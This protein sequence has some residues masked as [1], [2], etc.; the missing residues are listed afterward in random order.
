MNRCIKMLTTAV[1][2]VCQGGFPYC[3]NVKGVIARFCH[4]IF[5][6]LSGRAFFTAPPRG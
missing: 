5:T 4:N 3:A 2:F 6:L 1:S